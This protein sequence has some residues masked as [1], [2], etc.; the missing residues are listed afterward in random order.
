MQGRDLELGV[1]TEDSGLDLGNRR[2]GLPGAVLQVHHPRKRGQKHQKQ[3]QVL[4]ARHDMRPL[5]GRG[6]RSRDVNDRHRRPCHLP[7]CLRLCRLGYSACWF[8]RLALHCGSVGEGITCRRSRRGIRPPAW[9]CALK[10]APSSPAGRKRGDGL[11]L[12]C[13]GCAS[14]WRSAKPCRC[15]STPPIPLRLSSLWSWRGCRWGRRLAIFTAL[16]Y[17]LCQAWAC[18]HGFVLFVFVGLTRH[19]SSRGLRPWNR[20]VRLAGLSTELKFSVVPPG[21]F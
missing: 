3:A 7:L 13:I 8:A 18:Q 2:K 9:V 16:V 19:E 5:P 14:S 17:T 21:S 4:V 15:S 6:S 12:G 11:H 1:G 20:L 10:T